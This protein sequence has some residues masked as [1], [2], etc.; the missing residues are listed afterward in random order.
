MPVVIGDSPSPG[1]LHWI[2]SPSSQ[3]LEG[4]APLTSM[5]AVLNSLRR[6]FPVPVDQD[7]PDQTL[8]RAVKPRCQPGESIAADE[9]APRAYHARSL[10]TYAVFLAVSMNAGATTQAAITVFLRGADDAPPAAAIELRE[11]LAISVGQERRAAFQIDQIAAQIIAGEWMM[12]HPGDSLKS[13]SGQARKWEPVKA[14]ADGW[15]SGEALRG[16][17]V[18]TS[19]SAPE[20]LGDD[21][22]EAAG[23]GMVYVGGEPRAGDPYSTG[24]VHLPVRVRMGS[25]TFLFQVGRGRLKCKR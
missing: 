2:A 10:M 1:V 13:P 17:Y 14:A 3:S 12:P 22:R 8:G 25:N 19:R 20:A 15:F 23:H 5:V 4:G 16:G 11:G 9:N 21:A 6:G 7:F 18:A 24:Y